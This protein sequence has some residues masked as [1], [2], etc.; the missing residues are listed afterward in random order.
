L[1]KYNAGEFVTLY[2]WVYA[3]GISRSISFSKVFGGLWFGCRSSFTKILIL[4]EKINFKIYT[5]D[6]LFKKNTIFNLDKIVWH[7]YTDGFY[8]MYIKWHY[9]EKVASW[10]C[11]NIFFLF[12]E[13]VYRN[14]G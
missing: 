4:I 7:K 2:P 10:W 6:W 1:F 13:H 9:W 11:Q 3:S 14:S 8:K 12:S 5:S